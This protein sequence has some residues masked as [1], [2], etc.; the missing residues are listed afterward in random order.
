[1]TPLC[2]PSWSIFGIVPSF[3][4]EVPGGC[5]DPGLLATFKRSGSAPG[6]SASPDSIWIRVQSVSIVDV[7][8]GQK[9]HLPG[10]RGKWAQRAYFVPY[11]YCGIGV[12]LIMAPLGF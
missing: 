5:V 3:C 2:S 6:L 1:M 12:Q 4:F 8:K 10:A 9:H 11:P 7:Q